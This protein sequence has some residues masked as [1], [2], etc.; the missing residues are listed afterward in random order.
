MH[1]QQLVK[2]LRFNHLLLFSV[3]CFC[4]MYRCMCCSVGCRAS[5][6]FHGGKFPLIS[7]LDFRIPDHFIYMTLNKNGNYCYIPCSSKHTDIGQKFGNQNG[8]S[9]LSRPSFVSIQWL[10]KPVTMISQSRESK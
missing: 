2:P 4:C 5:N 10:T 3:V 9:L 1:F 8:F 7:R 6:S